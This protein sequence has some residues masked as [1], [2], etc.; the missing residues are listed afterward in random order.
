MLAGVAGCQHLALK[1]P[2]VGS[3][4]RA[5]FDCPALVRFA[6]RSWMSVP[7]S[8]TRWQRKI[9]EVFFVQSDLLYEMCIE[10]KNESKEDT[11]KKK[12]RREKGEPNFTV[13]FL[14]IAYSIDL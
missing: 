10:T 13:F 8:Y 9:L 4:S 7:P 2:V 11:K 3:S 12:K 14:P 6:T 1:Q 5:S